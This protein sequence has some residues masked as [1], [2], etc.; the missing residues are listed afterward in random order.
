MIRLSSLIL[1][2]SILLVIQA[3]NSSI[4]VESVF[5][6]MGSYDSIAEINYANYCAG[7]HGNNM[8]EF[9]DNE[10]LITKKEDDLFNIIKIGNEQSGMPGFATAFSDDEI[11]SISDLIVYYSKKPV[12]KEEIENTI[13]DENANYYIETVVSGLKIPWGIEFLPNGDLLI[14]EREG[15]LIRFSK[16]EISE[17]EGLPE[18]MAKGQGGLM[19][20]KLHPDFDKNGWIYIS[21]SYR[22]EIDKNSGNT[23]IMR[24]QLNGD[25]IIQPELLYKATPATER[26]HHF[27]SRIAFDNKGYMFFTVGDRGERPNGQTISTSNGKVHRLYDDGRI[28][29][30]NPFFG[31]TEAVQSIYSFG[32]RNPQ[33]LGIHP[34]TGQLWEHEHGPRGGDEVNLIEPGL[35]Y[36]W[37]VISFGINYDGTI[38]TNDTAMDGMV[39]PKAYYVPS[40]APCGLAFIKG[41]KYEGWENN[42]LVGSLRF[43]YIDRCI[44]EGDEIVQQEKLAEGI[45]RVREVAVSPDGYIYVGVENPGRIL[46]LVPVNYRED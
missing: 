18:I 17:I 19:D 1:G 24:F 33:G 12:T 38:F 37:P 14:T 29:E 42:L 7:C 32:H 40:I 13:P 25:N 30:D 34:E 45:G 6:S 46:K 21:Y 15:K 20:I 5:S 3:C 11:K 27:G 4:P 41:N 16:G 44:I 8:E 9:R 43:N 10:W 2:I 35:N 26:G 36:G 23:A 28:P 39:Q 31:R 22:E